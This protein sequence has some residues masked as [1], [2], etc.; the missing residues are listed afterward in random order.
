MNREDL[1]KFT[2]E[3]LIDKLISYHKTNESL[4]FENS[5]LQAE[6]TNRKLNDFLYDDYLE[7]KKQLEYE[8]QSNILNCDKI[9]ELDELLDRYKSIVDKLGSQTP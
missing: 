5:S 4:K 9:R 3:Q 6:I 2:K 8:R 1:M 7:T